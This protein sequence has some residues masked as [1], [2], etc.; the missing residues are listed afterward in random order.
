MWPGV[1][2]RAA[3]QDDLRASQGVDAGAGREP[4]ILQ[5]RDDH[6][7]THVDAERGDGAGRELLGLAQRGEP[8]VPQISRRLRP[9][10]EH[11]LRDAVRA[12]GELHVSGVGPGVQLL[13]REERKATTAA[14]RLHYGLVVERQ[15]SPQQRTRVF[16]AHGQDLQHLA[17]ELAAQT[18]ERVSDGAS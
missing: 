18:A 15:R 5:Q 10:R 7:D 1:A 3:G 9:N 11:L 2:F 12:F 17:L 8:R 4:E 16:A 14:R 13:Q 6:D